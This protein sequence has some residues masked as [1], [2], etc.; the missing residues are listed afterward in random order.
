MAGDDVFPRGSKARN[1]SLTTHPGR[2]TPR[3][4]AALPTHTLVFVFDDD[5]LLTIGLEPTQS[6][7]ST[8]IAT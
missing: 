2:R 5:R 8:K 3:R 7:L 4:L 1:G 6:P